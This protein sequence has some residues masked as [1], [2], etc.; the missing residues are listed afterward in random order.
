MEKCFPLCYQSK[1]AIKILYEL[2]Y[3]LKSGNSCSNVHKKAENI[4]LKS[5]IYLTANFFLN[6]AS[7]TVNGFSRLLLFFWNLKFSKRKFSISS[8]TKTQNTIKIHWSTENS[9]KSTSHE[10]PIHKNL[11]SHIFSRLSNTP[12]L[13]NKNINRNRL[14]KY[15]P[16][17]THTRISP[18]EFW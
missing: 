1:C 2:K 10:N 16:T 12:L 3:W 15:T 18:S 5:K 14:Q 13:Q 4:H 17:H 8:T 7:E 11:I 9:G 6:F